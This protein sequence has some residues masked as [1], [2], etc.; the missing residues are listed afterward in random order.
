MFFILLFPIKG[1]SFSVNTTNDNQ[2]MNMKARYILGQTIGIDGGGV[3][4]SKMNCDYEFNKKKHVLPDSL[5]R[6]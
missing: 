3:Y 4:V 1:Q 5:S 2:N 6:N